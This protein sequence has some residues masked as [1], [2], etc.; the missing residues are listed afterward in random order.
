LRTELFLMLD[1]YNQHLFQATADNLTD[2][3]FNDSPL[4]VSGSGTKAQARRMQ[5]L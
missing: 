1:W 2:A 5:G 3:L 4:G